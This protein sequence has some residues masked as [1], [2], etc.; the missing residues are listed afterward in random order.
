MKKK[1]TKILIILI[2]LIAAFFQIKVCLASYPLEGVIIENFIF[3]CEFFPQD[4]KFENHATYNLKNLDKNEVPNIVFFYPKTINIESINNSNGEKIE[5]TQNEQNQSVT[6]NLALK[7]E[8]SAN[9]TI[10]YSIKESLLIQPTG[11]FFLEAW[12]P[13]IA[14][15]CYAKGI[16]N[17]KI[18]PKEEVFSIGVKKKLEDNSYIFEIN[19]PIIMGGISVKPEKERFKGENLAINPLL[20]MNSSEKT[21]L[22]LIR[23][24][25]HKFTK[26]NNG[27]KIT[28]Y[29]QL[30]ISNKKNLTLMTN[31]I[32]KTFKFMKNKFGYD[33]I[34]AEISVFSG[35]QLTEE[36][37][38]YSSFGNIIFDSTLFEINLSKNEVKREAVY[39]TA[40]ETARTLWG[41]DI[42]AMGPG[43]HLLEEGAI[44]FVSS[45]IVGELMG[46]KERLELLRS[47]R[48]LYMNIAADR[49]Q[50]IMATS[51]SSILK[52]PVLYKKG[53]LILYQLKSYLEQKDNTVF[54]KAIKTFVKDYGKDIT[55]IQEFR[56][57][58][59][60]TAGENLDNAFL[61]WIDTPEVPYYKIIK[62]G[63]NKDEQGDFC[64]VII[65]NTGGGNGYVPLTFYFPEKILQVFVTVPSQDID[66]IKFYDPGTLDKAV[67]DPNGT[68]LCMQD[69]IPSGI[70]LS[71]YACQF[72]AEVIE[73]IDGTPASKTD[74]APGDYIIS[75]NK[76]PVNGMLFYQSMNLLYGKP[77]S[78][79]SIKVQKGG[80]VV[81]ITC[82]R[83]PLIK[84]REITDTPSGLPK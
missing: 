35:P 5:F 27:Q 42:T 84:Q 41:C 79:V 17:V 69:D 74:I 46:E 83:A 53:A 3:D 20:L 4:A 72:G 19:K 55:S 76:K 32:G 73:V 71:L 31:V 48:N 10:N 37:G 43:R 40:R 67:I 60:Q 16:L 14:A 12:F 23:G 6:V 51:A 26:D 39:I 50:S 29:S 15:P 2:I 9:I 25:F 61:C 21:K 11:S 34:P 22:I 80:E 1:N 49:D 63:N 33:N 30:P 66:Y 82:S 75:I 28:F 77:G 45:L 47:Y 44:D 57:V 70:G 24:H 64:Y 54:Y 56:T 52:Y 18:P 65:E 68:W 13:V 78:K 8:N 58:L 7:S 59:E 36:G 62:T 81:D 38:G